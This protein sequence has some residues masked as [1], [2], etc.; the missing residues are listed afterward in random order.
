MKNCF[1]DWSQSNS[2][3]AEPGYILLVNPVDM[4][5]TF[6]VLSSTEHEFQL[7]IK[8]K[9]LTKEEVSGFKSLRCCIY[10]ANNVKMPTIVG[11]LTFMSRI[12]FMLN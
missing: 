11:I 3:P 6:L 7:L 9:I 5:Q 12:N 4:G 10:H 1:K 8:T 2:C